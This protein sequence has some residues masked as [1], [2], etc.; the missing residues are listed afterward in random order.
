MKQSPSAFEI[1]SGSVQSEKK[2]IMARCGFATRKDTAPPDP[3]SPGS[4]KIIESN[5]NGV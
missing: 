1:K 4:L 2:E 3:L 5:Q